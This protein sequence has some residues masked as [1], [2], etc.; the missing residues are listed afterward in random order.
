M[1][2]YE[3]DCLFC[4]I[5]AGEIAAEVVYSD[6]AVVA[7][8][9]VNPRAPTHL[10]VIPRRHIPSAADLTDADGP[11]LAALFAALRHVAEE[12]GLQGYRIVTNVGAEAGQS[13]FHLHLHL[14]GGR[15]MTWP[16]G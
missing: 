7:F 8:R 5:A 9:D 3:P 1:A 4:R 14:L 2:D 6:D 11:T 13:V 12:S 10:L 15:A 16:P